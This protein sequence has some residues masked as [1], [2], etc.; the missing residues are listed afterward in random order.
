MLK[1][2]KSKIH[3]AI[4]NEANLD[5]T[6]SITIDPILMYKANLLPNECVLVADFS[7]GQRLETYVIEGKEGSGIICLNGPS[8]H[9]IQKGDKVAILAFSYL[10]ENEAL[11]QKPVIVIVDNKNRITEVK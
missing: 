5:Y 3:G 7:K 4:V 9:L 1:I 11:K 8:A 2:L 10:N 6:G